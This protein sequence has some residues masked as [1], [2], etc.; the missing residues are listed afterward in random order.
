MSGS[1]SPLPA[2]NKIEE[3]HGSKTNLNPRKRANPFPGLRPFEPSDA[4]LFFGRTKHV[5]DVLEHLKKHRFLAVIGVSGSGKSSLIRAGLIPRLYQGFLAA[6]G[7]RWKTTLLRPGKNPVEALNHALKKTFGVEAPIETRSRGLLEVIGKLIEHD[8]NLLIVVDQFEEIFRFKHLTTIEGPEGKINAVR[9]ASNFVRLLLT[10][11]EDE[12]VHIVIT[13]RSGYLGDCAQ[14]HEL[15]EHINKG[16][17]LVPRLTPEEQ[18]EII[19]RPIWARKAQ[20]SEELAQR[21]LDGIGP[22]PEA[23]P[24]LQHALSQLWQDWAKSSPENDPID[25][26]NFENIGGFEN[27]MNRHAEGVYG[28][29]PSDLH[30]WVAKRLFQRITLKGTAEQPIRRAETLRDIESI[31]ADA[32]AESINA[33]AGASASKILSDVIAAFRDKSGFIT[34]PEE[35]ELES[36][37]VIDISHESLCWLW[38]RLSAWVEEESDSESWYTLLSNLAALH[39]QGREGLYK[40]PGLTYV[41]NTYR[42]G[43]PSVC[44]PEKVDP[45]NEAWSRAYNKSWQQTAAFVR[46]SR[47][48]RDDLIAAEKA[49]EEAKLENERRAERAELLQKEAELARQQAELR[50]KELQDQASQERKEAELREKQFQAERKEA[51]LRQR[52][53]YMRIGFIILLICFAGV[54]VTYRWGMKQTLLVGWAQRS[55]TFTDQPSPSNLQEG[56]LLLLA[57]RQVS[58]SE[59]NSSIS[60]WEMIRSLRTASSWQLQS[61]TTLTACTEDGKY[62]ASLEPQK[63]FLWTA[64][65]PNWVELAFDSSVQHADL[66]QI[67]ISEDADVIVAGDKNGRVYVARG[68]EARTF[69]C[70][71]NAQ[72][73]ISAL[74]INR[75]NKENTELQNGSGKDLLFAVATKGNPSGSQLPGVSLFSVD[76]QAKNGS[77]IKNVDQCTWKPKLHRPYPK[78]IRNLSFSPRGTYVIVQSQDFQTSAV[79]LIA[80]ADSAAKHID[81]SEAP[82][83]DAINPVS[84]S[85]DERCLAIGHS[86]GITSVFAIEKGS[87]DAAPPQSTVQHSGPVV[88]VAIDPQCH[89]LISGSINGIWDITQV[90]ATVSRPDEI[91]TAASPLHLI[92]LSNDGR[93]LAVAG[94]ED[95]GVLAAP[96]PANVRDKSKK[97]PK[98]KYNLLQVYDWGT[99]RQ[100]RQIFYRGAMYRAIFPSNSSAAGRSKEADDK[101]KAVGRYITQLEIG[102]IDLSG[103]SP[104]SVQSLESFN[105]TASLA[106]GHY[107]AQVSNH[108]TITLYDMRGAHTEQGLS[109]STGTPDSDKVKWDLNNNAPMAMT[110]G[111]DALAVASRDGSIW[112]CIL[113]SRACNPILNGSRSAPLTILSLAISD[114]NRI[115]AGRSDGSIVLFDRGSLNGAQPTK[116]DFASQKAVTAVAIDRDGQVLA[117]GDESGQLAIYTLPLKLVPTQADSI[118]KTKK[119]V[120][121]PGSVSALRFSADGEY[122]AAGCQRQWTWVLT[123]KSGWNKPAYRNRIWHSSPVQSLAFAP[124][125][126]RLASATINEV[127]IY[128]FKSHLFERQSL[129]LVGVL[130]T[131]SI[132]SVSLSDTGALTVFER[133]SGERPELLKVE[134]MIVNDP[135]D[136]KLTEQTCSGLPKENRALPSEEYSLPDISPDISTW[137][138]YALGLYPR[139]CKSFSK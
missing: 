76:D 119:A 114:K 53:L 138:M 64:S 97:Y 51:T 78:P 103:S 80:V 27:A 101:S 20:I 6:A 104:P 38:K 44:D 96:E 52:R 121:M 18:R 135:D 117:A 85:K 21:L 45:W 93:Y 73:E 47:K 48:E 133:R 91:H 72:A 128:D 99:L 82:F 86:S 55:K 118:A 68:G 32:G 17:Y 36:E 54:V 110:S 109:L 46:L 1:S 35:G 129:E 8:E 26:T 11:L 100:I 59:E 15:P 10:A 115:S 66:T 30:K 95:V 31:I 33:D 77:D 13:M 81:T 28:A 4:A 75:P 122:L 37:S 70:V 49:Q 34:S 94:G 87:S 137:E 123:K 83:R 14:F 63:A 134:H 71:Y 24:I 29:L 132:A 98:T 40:D 139:A 92:S 124:K 41:L 62:C 127:K 57:S 131:A 61:P 9:D 58:R 50:E 113:Q 42:P 105:P 74:A 22:E 125:S 2:L 112:L 88:A 107:M 5:S 69:R 136:D 25:V 39:S 111:E 130:S 84:F 108:N 23:L 126:G 65:N 12:R 106:N 19:E 89:Q 90:S 43:E 67:A 79:D 120:E 102:D 3:G 56:V 116:L 60:A 16:Q 7:E